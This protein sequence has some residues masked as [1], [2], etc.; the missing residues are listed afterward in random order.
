MTDINICSHDSERESKRDR[1]TERKMSFAYKLRI[2]IS[3][4]GFEFY[5]PKM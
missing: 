4:A 5:E 1:E 3:F 2:K